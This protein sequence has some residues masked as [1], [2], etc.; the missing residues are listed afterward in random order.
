MLHMWCVIIVPITK[1]QYI[2][3]IL[4]RNF[5]LILT[6]ERIRCNHTHWCNPCNQDMDIEVG[7]LFKNDQGEVGGLF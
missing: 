1:Y 7:G 2:V 6:R 3:Y 5:S 4:T